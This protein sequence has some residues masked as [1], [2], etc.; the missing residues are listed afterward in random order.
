MDDPAFMPSAA[1][2]FGV[3]K[4]FCLL[5]VLSAV[6]V[7]L[8][9]RRHHVVEVGLLVGLRDGV[10]VPRRRGNE[11]CSAAVRGGT[12]SPL[13]PGHFGRTSTSVVYHVVWEQ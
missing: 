2:E 6:W 8:L 4:V 13:R 10:A 12:F 9:G 3:V 5:G 11:S 1:I 7:D